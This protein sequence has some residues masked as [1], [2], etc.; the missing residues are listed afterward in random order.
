MPPPLDYSLLDLPKLPGV[1]PFS[2]I[3][4]VDELL[5]HAAHIVEIVD[6]IDQVEQLLDGI[7]R[8][9]CQRDGN[10]E[11]LAAPIAQRI[12]SGSGGSSYG[13]GSSWGGM[14]LVMND[15][16]MTWLTGKIYKTPQ[17]QWYGDPPPTWLNAM[18]R[19]R[20]IQNMLIEG[21]PAQLLSTPSYTGGWVDP[22]HLVQRVAD[23]LENGYKVYA[24][25]LMLA[26]L[27][28][29]PVGRR[30]ALAAAAE[31]PEE[32]GRIVRFALGGDDRA[33]KKD[34]RHA[35]V[36][37][38]AGRARDPFGSLREPLEA[39]ADH[40]PDLP[41]HL[42]P[43][44]YRWKSFSE[45]TEHGY[46]MRRMKFGSLSKEE[47]A[48]ARKYGV[49]ERVAKK[50]KG[51]MRWEK[52]P[53]AAMHTTPDYSWGSIYEMSA[54]WRIDWFVMQWPL[55]PEPALQFGCMMLEQRLDEDT[56]R[57]APGH[58]FLNALF[59]PGRCW[60]EMAYL[61]LCLGLTSKSADARGYAID[62][63]IP[64]IESGHADPSRVVDVFARL[65][66]GEMLRMNRLAMTLPQVLDVSHLHKWWVA[67]VMCGVIA[68]VEK[69]PRKGHF[70]YELALDS[71]TPIGCAV[72][73]AAGLTLKKLKGSSKAAKLARE[74]LALEGTALDRPPEA[75]IAEAL[76][77]RIEFAESLV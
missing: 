75:V 13:L 59:E 52:W 38:C 46:K 3:E 58:V 39:I 60:G 11:K 67:K 47:I 32:E 20:E 66:N 57:D 76:R 14:P 53:I 62:A 51:K 54:P 24:A 64:C 72:P 55:N 41:G 71:L 16:V 6:S 36:W 31:L 43:G 68:S 42:A 12:G 48:G 44:E 2:R 73:E 4:T 35:S 28:L 33:G 17:N 37:L 56:S 22:M 21:E 10:F 26:L 9:G 77:G 63:V 19:L 65:L 40:I 27:R 23:H 8:L 18:S 70:L 1:F 74:L 30:E 50:I 29:S 69:P 5:E 49:I 7:A 61:A 34:K 45:V 25:D 15:L